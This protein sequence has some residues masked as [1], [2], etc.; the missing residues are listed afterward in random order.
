MK[1][2]PNAWSI[3]DKGVIVRSF[4]P[5]TGQWVA[6]IITHWPTEAREKSIHRT[7]QF[8]PGTTQAC[9]KI[10]TENHLGIKIHGF[11]MFRMFPVDCPIFSQIF[12]HPQPHLF[13]KGHQG[14]RHHQQQCSHPLS[15]WDAPSEP[16]HLRATQL[17]LLELLEL[18]NTWDRQDKVRK[19]QVKSLQMSLWVHE[20]PWKSMKYGFENTW[21]LKL[22][23]IVLGIVRSF[24]KMEKGN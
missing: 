21:R 4:F 18:G 23:Q 2:H 14:R 11:E 5:P 8:L 17:E 7:A 9:P 6:Q 1:S 10:G 15:T 24:W 20:N 13:P 3:L 22:R 19:T 12:S 16:S